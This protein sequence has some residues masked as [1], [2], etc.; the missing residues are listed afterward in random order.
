MTHLKSRAYIRRSYSVDVQRV[1]VALL[2]GLF[3]PL[4]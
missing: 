3:V 1:H 2:N 4:F